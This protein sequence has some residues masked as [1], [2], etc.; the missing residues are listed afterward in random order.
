MNLKI[1]SVVCISA[2]LA[3]PELAAAAEPPAP[4]D[5]GQL[6]SILDSCSAAK[7][8]EAERYKKQREKLTEGVA[9]KE[10]TKIRDSDEYKGAY[11]SIRERFDH[12][13][14]DEV[15]K[16]CNVILGRK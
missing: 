14:S 6:E 5:L 16:A 4:A 8:K 10:V 13:S 1:L 15:D 3:I 11:N 2:A 7:P 9:E 12:A